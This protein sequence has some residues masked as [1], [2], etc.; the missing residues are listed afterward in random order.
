VAQR[1]LAPTVRPTG[2]AID[3]WTPQNSPGSVEKV[4]EI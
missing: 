3:T 4:K 2:D 1:P